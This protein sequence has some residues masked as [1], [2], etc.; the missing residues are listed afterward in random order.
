MTTFAVADDFAAFYQTHGYVILRDAFDA[1]EIARIQADVFD[2]YDTRFRSLNDAGMAGLDLL[3][4]FHAHDRSRWQQC[5]RRMFDLLSVYRLA[6]K[7]QVLE[8]LAT[9]GLQKPMIS[10]RPEVRTDMPRDEQYMQGWHQD[11]RYGQGS[12][13]S[14]TF[15]V[16]LHDVGVDH[17]TVE[18]MPA[19][20]LMG[21]LE[22]E[23]LSNP[24]RFVIPEALLGSRP[25][26]PVPLKQGEAL[27]FS[28]MLV[29]RS[30]YNRSGRPR[31][32]TQ[33]RFVDY[34]ESQFIDQGLPA[35]ATSDLLWNRTPSAADMTAVFRPLSLP[36]TE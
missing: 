26:F 21:Y 18:V 35:P 33:L 30:G 17:G 10:T 16:P 9:L 34:A 25:S 1:V 14:V 6:A 7:P 4:H 36:A 27:V 32:T 29:H 24:R 28:Q 23:E 22:C 19:T 2:L 20:H 12:L 31:L 11:W 8:V 13:N 15:W 3:A 5:A